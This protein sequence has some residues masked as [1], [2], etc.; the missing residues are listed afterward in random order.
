[1]QPSCVL[2]EG[3]IRLGGQVEQGEG[4]R[5]NYFQ[6]TPCSGMEQNVNGP[7]PSCEA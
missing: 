7:S 5:G 2:R 3:E 6:D 4:E 1:M